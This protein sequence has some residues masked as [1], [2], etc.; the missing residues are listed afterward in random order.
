M[1]ENPAATILD[2]RTPQEFQEKHIPNATLLPLDS[3][4]A[5]APAALPDKN[6][7]ILVYCRRGNRSRTAANKLIF[8]GYTDVYDFGGIEGW[9][10]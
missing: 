7:T 8:M 10:E 5:K 6:A 3:I 4:S 1:G 9:G 2:V